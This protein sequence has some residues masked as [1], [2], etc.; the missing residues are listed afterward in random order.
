MSVY[1]YYLEEDHIYRHPAFKGV[2]FSNG[3]VSIAN[4][5]II[6]Y[7]GYAWDGCS[8]KKHLFGMFIIGTP[9][10]ALRFG[11]PWTYYAS[12]VHDVL[13]QFRHHIPLSKEQVTQ[14]FNDQLLEAKWPLRRPYVWA[15]D[16]FGPQNFKVSQ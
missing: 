8:P 6:I 5:Q 16:N 1:Q 15:V 7:K 12:L 11:K 4:G 14:I 13:C 3:W 9:D 10:G 2:S